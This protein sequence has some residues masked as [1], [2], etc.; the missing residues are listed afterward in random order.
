[1]LFSSM[2]QAAAIAYYLV[3]NVPVSG[4]LARS[5]LQILVCPRVALSALKFST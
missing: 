4:Y 2:F 5:S 1:M 3:K